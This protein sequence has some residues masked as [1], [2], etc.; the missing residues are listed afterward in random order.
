LADRAPSGRAR[1]PEWE[2]SGRVRQVSRNLDCNGANAIALSF[3]KDRD[4][5]TG[6][7]GD[8]IVLCASSSVGGRTRNVWSLVIPSQVVRANNLIFALHEAAKDASLLPEF[9]CSVAKE[10]RAHLTGIRIYDAANA[11]ENYLVSTGLSPL[12]WAAFDARSRWCDVWRST[13]IPQMLTGGISHSGTVMPWRKLARTAWYNDYAKHIDVGH[14]MGF[15]LWAHV[16][17]R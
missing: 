11:S 1:C 14:G 6:R 12:E 16:V 4:E 17:Y 9:V 8:S 5:P 13:S 10:F 3:R 15:C 7:T 2:R